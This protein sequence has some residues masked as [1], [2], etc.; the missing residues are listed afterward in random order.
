NIKNFRSKTALL[1][2]EL[3][4]EQRW[5]LSG[6]RLE[7]H[8]SE[9]WSIFDFLMPGFLGSY[10][11]FKR[12]YQQPVENERSVAQMERLRRRIFPFLLRRL[13]DEVAKELPPKT[14]MLQY[15]EMTH[16]QRR[17]Y[18]EVLASCRR[19]VFA[20]I[21][22]KGVERSQVSILTALLRLRQ[23]CCHPE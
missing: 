19:Q 18:H 4:A 8:L 14:E 15:C 2:K 21:E 11:H 20:D 1:V 6:T 13:K 10:P 16:E 9:L 7:N 3:Q 12:L 23:V 17:L 22:Q 5:A